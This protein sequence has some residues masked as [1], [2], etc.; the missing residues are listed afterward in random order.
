MKT[1]ESGMPSEEVWQGFFDAEAILKKLG[2]TS[3]CKNVVDFGCGYGTFTIPAARIVSGSVYAL[4]IEPEMVELTR[5]KAEIAGLKNIDVR[6]CDFVVEGTGLSDG[7]ADYAML[8]NI[9]MP[10][11]ERCYCKRRGESFKRTA[12]WW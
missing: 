3:A 5:C 11:N 9:F 4:D 1:R 12:S 6:Q 2:L 7:S 10:R 8:F